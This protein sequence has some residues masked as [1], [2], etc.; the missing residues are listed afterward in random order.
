MCPATGRRESMGQV[1]FNEKENGTVGRDFRVPL[2]QSLITGR[3]RE[4]GEKQGTRQDGGRERWPSGSDL[5]RQRGLALHPKQS[6]EGLGLGG[7]C[8]SKADTK[9]SVAVFM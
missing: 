1:S 3:A 5:V 6:R 7:C 4:G 9:A 2:L 8:G